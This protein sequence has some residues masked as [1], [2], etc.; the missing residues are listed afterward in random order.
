MYETEKEAGARKGQLLPFLM[1]LDNKEKMN[2]SEG[3][4][5]WIHISSHKEALIFKFC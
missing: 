3:M 1:D 4:T 5:E 2:F